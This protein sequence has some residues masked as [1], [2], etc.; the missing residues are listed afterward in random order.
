M[1]YEWDAAKAAA[2]VMKHGVQFSDAVSVFGDDEA[3]SIHDPNPEEERFITIGMDAFARV[4]VV[5]YTFRIG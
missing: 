3:I 5:V 2:N 1:H 4:L